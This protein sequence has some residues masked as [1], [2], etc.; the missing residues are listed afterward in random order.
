MQAFFNAPQKYG[1]PLPLNFMKTRSINKLIFLAN[2]ELEA[3][4]N[5]LEQA[6]QHDLVSILFL[7]LNKILIL[8]YLFA[9]KSIK[10]IFRPIEEHKSKRSYSSP[11]W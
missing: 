1:S 8:I 2:I 7:L 3:A 9:A 5:F 10:T 4:R 6:A 11:S